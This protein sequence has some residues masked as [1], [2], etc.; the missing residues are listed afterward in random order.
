MSKN[1]ILL[2]AGTN[3]LEIIE[4][5]LDEDLKE[6]SSDDISGYRGYYGVNVAKVLEITNLPSV[7]EL[8]DSPHPAVLGAFN[9]RSS[10]IPLI[11][12]SL[13]LGKE[14]KK[15]GNE[16]VI[17]TE[18]NTQVTAFLVSGVNRIHRLSWEQVEA[19]NEYISKF[20]SNTITS[21]VRLEKRVIFILDLE[22]IVFGLNPNVTLKLDLDANWK[23]EKNYSALV[24]DDSNM[25][26]HMLKELLEQAGFLVEACKNGKEA[27][28]RL[29]AL[30]ATAEKENRQVS[31]YVQI[32]VS[33][34][35][36]PGMDGLNLTKRVK[37]DAQLKQL[38]VILFSSL[39]SE[40][41]RHKGESVGADD[42]ITKPEVGR[43]AMTAKNLIEQY[44]Q[45]RKPA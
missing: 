43:L 35:E 19:P 24:A 7:T 33:D 29:E 39:I 44:A 37:E 6:N 9:Q 11:D 30:K 45:K 5:Y 22:E 32:L 12:L 17:I 13:W 40:R 18:F 27:W 14:R 10:I 16:K 41:S 25:I 3:E 23:N 42:Q 15:T 31:D 20:S 26:R 38:P 8:P 2:E 4:F 36:M 28:D 21:I 1:R 34:I